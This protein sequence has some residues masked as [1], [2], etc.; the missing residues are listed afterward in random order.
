MIEGPYKITRNELAEFLPSQRAIRAFEQLFALIPSSLNDSAAVIEEVSVNAQNADSKAVQALSAI[1]RLANAV[2]LLAL[3][4]NSIPAFPQSDI[5]PPVTVVS[6][7]PDILPPVIGE[8]RRKRYGVFHSTVT[9]TA[10]AINTAYPMTLNTTDISFGVYIGS[11]NSRVYIDTEGF[12]NFQ[13]SAQ[14][15]KI[16]GG[17]GAIYIWARVN[18]VDIPDSATKIRIQGN[19]AETVGAWNFVLPVNAGDY[20]ELVWSTDDTSCEILALPASAPVPALPSL[21]LTV[22]DNIS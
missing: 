17:V 18:G 7:Q 8:V 4:P 12:Y 5:V 1:D 19:N 13:F 9:Q 2:E 22:T 11:P 20:F 14:L 10:A 6:Q 3:A 15:H 21:I 16:A